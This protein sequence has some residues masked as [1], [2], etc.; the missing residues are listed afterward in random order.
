MAYTDGVKSGK[1][2]IGVVLAVVIVVAFVAFGGIEVAKDM[3]ANI[4]K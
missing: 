1:R 3:F 2:V 4:Q